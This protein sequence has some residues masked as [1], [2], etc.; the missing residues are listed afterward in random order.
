MSDV[1]HTAEQ[2]MKKTLEQLTNELSKIR[3]GRANTS[4]L[5]GIK[6]SCY[7][8][9]TPLSQVASIN[10]EDARTLTVSPWDK[11]LV[12]DIERAITTSD[13]GLNPASMGDLIRIPL[14]P[15][16]EERRRDFVKQAKSVG[17]NSK[18]GI[19]NA[20]RDALSELKDQVK[21]K[22]ITEDD[23][24]KLQAKMQT[25]TD[26]YIAKVEQQVAAKEE[27]LLKI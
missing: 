20:R 15:L 2:K 6:V 1:M 22:E 18:I 23:E 21:E 26:S 4:L 5:D 13:L 10:V 24:R 19:R 16:S 17:E 14:P 3:T 27:D 12:A 11:S 7:G 8:S 25:L 9:L